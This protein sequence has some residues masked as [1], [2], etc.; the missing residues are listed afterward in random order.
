MATHTVNDILVLSKEALHGLKQMQQIGSKVFSR[1][2]L[3]FADDYKKWSQAM[4]DSR[5]F[6]EEIKFREKLS[7]A[8]VQNEYIKM[9]ADDVINLN[10]FIQAFVDLLKELEGLRFIAQKINNYQYQLDSLSK[11]FGMATKK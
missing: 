9:T 2:N 10:N 1:L 11:L 6:W 7:L 5:A 3:A 4:D 8:M